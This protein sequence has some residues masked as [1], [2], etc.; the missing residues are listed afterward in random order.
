[1]EATWDGAAAKA[2]EAN[3]PTNRPATAKV[4]SLKAFSIRLNM[5]SS[6]LSCAGSVFCPSRWEEHEL[7]RSI[8]KIPTGFEI[9][10][11]MLYDGCAPLPTLQSYAM[12]ID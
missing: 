8:K 5:S 9:D 10:S 4:Q 6:P 1:M 11:S 7:H 3:E 12:G 2:V